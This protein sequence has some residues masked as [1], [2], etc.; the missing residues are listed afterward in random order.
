M[1]LLKQAKPAEKGGAERRGAERRPPFNFGAVFALRVSAVKAERLSEAVGGA[2]SASGGRGVP[3]SKTSARAKG[4][5]NAR[6]TE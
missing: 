1:L 2:K 3:A 5:Q 6:A 4:A